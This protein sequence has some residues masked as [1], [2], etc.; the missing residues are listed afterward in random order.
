MGIYCKDISGNWKDSINAEGRLASGSLNRILDL[1]QLQGS[2]L[3]WLSG[4][5][6]PPDHAAWSLGPCPDSATLKHLL[7]CILGPERLTC[8]SLSVPFSF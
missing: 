7:P 5:M 4:E 8:A 2:C 3:S 6:E 1:K